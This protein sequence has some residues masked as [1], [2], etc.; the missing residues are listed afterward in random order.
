MQFALTRETTISQDYEQLIHTNA[1]CSD[2]RNNYNQDYE[3][4]IHSNAICSDQRNNYK[5]RL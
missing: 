2:L 4:L 3:Q 1:I 5:P